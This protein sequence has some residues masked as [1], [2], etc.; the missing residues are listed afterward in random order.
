MTG[1]IKGFIA[2]CR[3]DDD[4]PDFLSYHCI[5]HQQV[6]TSKRLNTKSVMDITF[7][8]VNSIRGQSLQ[9]R[10]FKMQLGEKNTDLILHTDVRWLSRS[11]FL[12]RF[13]DL[14][15]EIKTF[16]EE[17]GDDYRELQDVVWLCDLAFLTDFTGKLSTLN[18]EL[19]GREKTVGDMIGLISAYQNQFEM[20]ITDLQQ[21]NFDH[22]P[23]LQDHKNKY[24]DFEIETEKFV[25]E[26]GKVI[27]DFESRFS[28]L[29]KIE[30]IIQYLSFP[31]RQDLDRKNIA[32]KISMIF[33]MDN[34][35]LENEIITLQSDIFLKA[36]SSEEEFWKYVS[37]DKYSNIRKCREMLHSFSSDQHICVNL[38]FHT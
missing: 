18:L 9:R 16:L 26:I 4:F 7:K 32:G 20:M 34:V 23:N 17:R 28:D 25:D 31:F 15:S 24:P 33:S 10:L 5:I 36:R 37:R 3:K 30:D 6:L 21:N 38:H 2:L 35:S 12:Q 22:F 27:Q 14:L 13:R 11:K 1:H 29:K 8:I 19:Q